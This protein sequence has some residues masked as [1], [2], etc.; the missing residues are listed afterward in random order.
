MGHFDIAGKVGFIT[1]ASHGLG[2]HFA[3]MVERIP[4]RRTGHFEELDGP[5]LLL[6][7]ESSRYMMGSVLTVDGGYTSVSA[8]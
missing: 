5:L 6:A 1:G 3:T 8:A 4:Q 2:R 7:S